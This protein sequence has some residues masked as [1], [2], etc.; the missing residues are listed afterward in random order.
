M[1][2]P[3][4][5]SSLG[6]AVIGLFLPSHKPMA[7]E[8]SKIPVCQNQKLKQTGFFCQVSYS[9]ILLCLIIRTSRQDILN[10]IRS[11]CLVGF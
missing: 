4:S 8:V 11:V 5:L 7:W 1:E 2:T 6:M 9:N 3:L 10:E